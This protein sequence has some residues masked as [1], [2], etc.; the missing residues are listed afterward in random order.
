MAWES[1][2]D[3]WSQSGVWVISLDHFVLVSN[4]EF[5]GGSGGKGKRLLYWEFT[6]SVEKSIRWFLSIILDVTLWPNAFFWSS[7]Y[8]NQLISN[9]LIFCVYLS[10]KNLHD[11]YLVKF[12][13]REFKIT[14]VQRNI[15]VIETKEILC[16]NL[17]CDLNINEN[18]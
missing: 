4:R 5:C 11:H 3:G 1:M 18:H 7:N 13:K 17:C 9:Q 10:K 15:K 2:C 16:N 8:L 6:E 12:V 14:V